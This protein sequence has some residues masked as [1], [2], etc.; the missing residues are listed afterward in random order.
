MKAIKAFIHRHRIADVI[1]ALKGA[2][3]RNLTLIDAKGMLKALDEAEREYSLDLG[4]AVVSEIKL[5]LVC[6]SGRVDEAVALIRDNA[7]TG[8]WEAGWIYVSAIEKAHR[9]GNEQA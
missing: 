1:D 3:F 8:Q 4:E 9:I 6:E 5:E 2:G 7:Q